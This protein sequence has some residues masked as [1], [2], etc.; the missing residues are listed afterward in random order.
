MSQITKPTE[1]IQ[2]PAP[3]WGPAVFAVGVLGLVAGTFANDF[4]FPAWCYAA[5]GFFFVLFSLRSMIR[6]GRRAYYS[7]PREQ[8]DVRAELPVESFSAPT[9]E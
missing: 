1:T 4:M 6:K 9:A 5:V 8:E 3:S 2:L 7:L